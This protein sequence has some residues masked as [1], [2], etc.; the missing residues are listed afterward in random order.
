MSLPSFLQAPLTRAQVRH[1][2]IAGNVIRRLTGSSGKSAQASDAA[3]DV[4]ETAGPLTRDNGIEAAKR[5]AGVP[6][7]H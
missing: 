3:P 7:G 2:V 4:P 6:S 1:P 5:A